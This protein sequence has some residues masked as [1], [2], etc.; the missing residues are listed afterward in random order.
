MNLI[1]GGS[2][3]YTWVFFPHQH[4]VPA[5]CGTSCSQALT[6]LEEIRSNITCGKTVRTIYGKIQIQNRTQVSNHLDDPQPH[7]GGAWGWQDGAL[8][9]LPFLHHQPPHIH[10]VQRQVQV[11]IPACARYKVTLTIFRRS[12]ARLVTCRANG[13]NASLWSRSWIGKM[14]LDK[15]SFTPTCDKTIWTLWE[16]AGGGIVIMCRTKLDILAGLTICAR[17][18]QRWRLKTTLESHIV[19]CHSDPTF[20]DKHNVNIQFTSLIRKD[21]LLDLSRQMKTKQKNT[22]LQISAHNISIK[23]RHLEDQRN[24]GKYNRRPRLW[25]NIVQTGAAARTCEDLPIFLSPELLTE[26]GFQLFNA[27]S[28]NKYWLQV[29]AFF[30]KHQVVIITQFVRISLSR[31]KHDVV[32]IN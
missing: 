8:V 22:R 20:R 26:Y 25:Y 4:F 21:A 6:R 5:V 7:Q 30:M 19:K 15:G 24:A 11:S 2:Y 32:K 31:N 27:L 1:L 10:R 28:H 29:P 17:D 13:I 18:M 14:V 23:L 12:F 9:G 16:C 3:F